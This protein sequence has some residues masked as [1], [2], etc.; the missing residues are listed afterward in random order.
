MI[1]LELQRIGNSVGIV[2]PKE[3]CKRFQLEAGDRV[4]LVESESGW[5]LTASDPEFARQLRAADE[6]M[7]DYRDAPRELAR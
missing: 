2:L 1:E 3:V 5:R 4:F 7:R 6:V